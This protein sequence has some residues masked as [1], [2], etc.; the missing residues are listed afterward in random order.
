MN[1]VSPLRRYSRIL[2]I[3][4]AVL[5]VISTVSQQLLSNNIFGWWPILLL[6]MIGIQWLLFAFVSKFGQHKPP[7]LLKQYQIAKYAKLFAYMVGMALFTF[8]VFKKPEVRVAFLLTF[9]VYYLVFTFLE[10][11]F[12]HKWMN[13]LPRTPERKPETPVEEPQTPENTN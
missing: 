11:W 7:T 2:L 10:T 4:G 5:V 3:T 6:F 1:S 8:L 12:V 9:I 13:A